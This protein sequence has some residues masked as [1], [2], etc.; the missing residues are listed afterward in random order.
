M[1]TGFQQ[2]QPLNYS[3]AVRSAPSPQHG[4]HLTL[5]SEATRSSSKAAIAPEENSVGPRLKR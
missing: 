3:A 1:N 5:K 2:Q 4:A